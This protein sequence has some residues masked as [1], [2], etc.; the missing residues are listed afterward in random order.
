MIRL[1]RPGPV[2]GLAEPL[3]V[4]HRVSTPYV[5]RQVFH[6]PDGKG[7][8]GG[9]HLTALHSSSL[10]GSQVLA[11]SSA[12]VVDITRARVFGADTEQTNPPSRYS[13]R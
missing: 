13:S 7:I 11:Y 6:E 9:R 1:V 5:S 4:N 10:G 8:T 12:S 3:F 2:I